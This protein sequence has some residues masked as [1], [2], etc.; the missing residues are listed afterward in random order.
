MCAE[1]IADKASVCPHCG[2]VLRSAPQPESGP[3]EACR[4]C[5][6][7]IPIGIR[8]CPHC[9]TILEAD[10]F[11]QGAADVAR[12]LSSA[13]EEVGAAVARNVSGVGEGVTATVARGLARREEPGATPMNKR[14]ATDNRTVNVDPEGAS[15]GAAAAPVTEPSSSSRS[16]T[17]TSPRKRGSQVAIAVV[18]VVLVGAASLGGV[19]WWVMQDDVTATTDE[20]DPADLEPRAAAGSTTSLPVEVPGVQARGGGSSSDGPETTGDAPEE[21]AP[22]APPSCPSGMVVVAAATFNMGSA[23]AGGDAARHQVQ[24]GMRGR[25]KSLPPPGLAPRTSRSTTQRIVGVR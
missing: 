13:A 12:T 9:G 14:A 25:A 19:A 23:N 4:A 10:G 18:A 17:G 22:A 8:E 5:A 11:E 15:S 24:L 3:V 2:S 6:E 7:A 16:H 20:A 21:V 1:P